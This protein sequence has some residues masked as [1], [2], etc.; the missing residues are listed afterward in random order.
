MSKKVLIPIEYTFITQR[1]IEYALS[2][3]QQDDYEIY[4]FRVANPKVVGRSVRRDTLSN[5][6][7]RAM[8]SM[9]RLLMRAIVE[10]S[11]EGELDLAQVGAIHK[12]FSVGDLVTEILKMAGNI[13]SDMIL[14]GVP[15]REDPDYE[16]GQYNFTGSAIGDLVDKAPCSVYVRKTFDETFILL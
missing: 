7:E 3:A 14:M 10:V 12:R 2:L 13:S 8:D 5:A 4:L 16:K 1:T 9:D 6:L 11:K 15:S